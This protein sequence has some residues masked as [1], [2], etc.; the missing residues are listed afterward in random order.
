MDLA[1]RLV[2]DDVELG[3]LFFQPVELAEG[4]VDVGPSGRS[5]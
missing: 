5:T 1:K 4:C 3:F 2:P